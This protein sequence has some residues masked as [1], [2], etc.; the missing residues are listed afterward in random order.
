MSLLLTLYRAFIILSTLSLSQSLL[1]AES[2]NQRSDFIQATKLLKQNNIAAFNA[3]KDKLIDY[4]LHDYLE[5]YQFRNNIQQFNQDDIAQ[6]IDRHQDM[7]IA[8]TLIH[9]RLIYLGQQQRWQEYL[10]TA[11]TPPHSAQLAC[12][13]YRAALATGDKTTAYR[14]AKQLWLTGQSQDKACDPLF[15]QWAKDG[16]LSDEL[17][18][19]RQLLAAANNNY[20]LMRY[21]ARKTRGD[22]RTY[23]NELIH[24]Y[25]Q[26]QHFIK[27]LPLTYPSA[28]N[29]AIITTA[30]R[31][32]SYQ[33]AARSYQLWQ[34]YPD[35]I[36]AIPAQQRD[37]VNQQLAKQLLRQNGQ[38]SWARAQARRYAGN[39]EKLTIQ[40]LRSDLARQDW[41]RL[42]DF[43][44]QLPSAIRQQ[45]RWQYWSAR[46]KEQLGIEAANVAKL[47]QSLSLQRHYYGFLAAARLQQ[48]IHFQHSP[49]RIS[50][51]NRQAIIESAPF[52]RVKELMA[53]GYNQTA[54]KEWRHLLSKANAEQ[55]SVLGQLAI[56]YGWGNLAINQAIQHGQ[57]NNMGLRAPMAYQQRIIRAANARN[58][59][60]AWA[61][62]I[63]RQESLFNSSVYSSAGAVG[64]M[65]LMPTTAK[66]MAKKHRI[67]LKHVSDLEQPSTNIALGSGYLAHLYR[68]F[69]GS[70]IYAT[71]AYNAGPHRVRQWLKRYSNLED[72]MWTETI[73]FKETRNY[74]KNVVAFQKIYHYQL[75]NKPFDVYK[76]Q[77]S[78]AL[79]NVEAT[80]KP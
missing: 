58:I 61:F 57:R 24:A 47:Y 27:P 29:A 69:D 48:P 23:S 28:V 30:A 74:V 67:P 71:A 60:S 38:H 45:Q 8:N 66:Q 65:Q 19:Q 6:F 64:L 53:I 21:L 10:D 37:A 9:R 78:I 72:D 36:V 11:K 59:D 39:N 75:H 31:R 68:Q 62:S 17:I 25:R 63:A 12:F 51:I 18:W 52:Q 54:I 3:L 32:L 76:I 77:P 4:P 34:Q 33:S 16:R 40:V 70:L 13:Y 46:S 20:S 41:R 80:P 5:Y 79:N 22:Y 7:P 50:A 15:K 35:S 14:G 55:Q 43:I 56:D 1:A 44:D 26:P 49:Y 73:P 42:N 2:D